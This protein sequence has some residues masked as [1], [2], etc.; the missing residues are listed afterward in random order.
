METII[1]GWRCVYYGRSPQDQ[2]NTR[3]NKL[4]SPKRSLDLQKPPF[5]AA[6]MAIEQREVG[7]KASGVG[8]K[9]GRSSFISGS[10]ID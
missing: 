2:K 7:G 3:H 4:L 5:D 9:L 6:K 1:H 10:L 8:E